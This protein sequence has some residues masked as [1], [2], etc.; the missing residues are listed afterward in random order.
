MRLLLDE[1]HA[2]AVGAELRARGYDVVAV[3]ERPDLIG[4][5]DHS[6]LAAATQ[7]ERAVVTENVRDFAPL[8]QWLT[9]AGEH[10]VGLVFTHPRR[11]PRGARNHVR[12]LS[13][14]LATFLDEQSG[15]LADV[16]SFVWWLAKASR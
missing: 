3:K 5:A 13:D 7:E 2:P 15:P 8:H 10:H 12:L 1:M 11:F 9:G 14:A 6:L 4:A 16:Q